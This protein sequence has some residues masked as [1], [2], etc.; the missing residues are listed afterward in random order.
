[1]GIRAL[2]S[3][4]AELDAFNRAFEDERFEFT[5]E[6]RRVAVSTR[7]LFLDWFPWLP[8]RFGER[9]I[10]ALLDE[11]LL[12]AFGFPHPTR[13]ERAAVEAALRARARAVRLLPPRRRPRLR[14][15][16]PRRSHPHGYRIDDL[17]P[18]EDRDRAGGRA[19][20]VDPAP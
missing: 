11:R 4:L 14:T 15:A 20:L 17:G 1:M 9:A 10:H 7:D 2:P 3:T 6:G 5:P 16:L 12:D 8:R 13:I 18:P 19:Q